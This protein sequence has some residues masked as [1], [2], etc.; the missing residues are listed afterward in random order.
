MCASGDRDEC[1]TSIGVCFVRVGI[2]VDAGRMNEYACLDLTG[3]TT[4][5]QECLGSPVVDEF[6]SMQ[7]CCNDADRC[8]VQTPKSPTASLMLTFTMAYKDPTMNTIVTPIAMTRTTSIT[9]NSTL[10]MYPL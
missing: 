2:S 8:N 4:Q 9:G 7:Q 3:N 6:T 1:V 5:R 10:G